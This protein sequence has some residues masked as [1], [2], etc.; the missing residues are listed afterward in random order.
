MVKVLDEGLRDAILEAEA[1]SRSC[2]ASPRVDEHPGYSL[3]VSLILMRTNI[4]VDVMHN[5]DCCMLRANPENVLDAVPQTLDGLP[6]VASNVKHK[7]D[8]LRVRTEPLRLAIG[9]SRV[10]KRFSILELAVLELL[11]L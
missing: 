5:L 4:S 1:M 3:L 8:R 2:S 7:V 11:F 10:T 6:R 9:R